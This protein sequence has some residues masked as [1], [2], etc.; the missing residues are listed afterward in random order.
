MCKQKIITM[1]LNL[2][3]VNSKKELEQQGY[4]RIDLN[5][6]YW[7]YDFGKYVLVADN[8]LYFET[9]GEMFGSASVSTIKEA[10][11]IYNNGIFKI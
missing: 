8:D 9:G 3:K 1:K 6:G 5:K 2:K 7:D 11:D 10:L 4:C